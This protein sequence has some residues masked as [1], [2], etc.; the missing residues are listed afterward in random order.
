MLWFKVHNI[1]NPDRCHKVSFDSFCLSW[2][3][4]Y[5][6]NYLGQREPAGRQRSIV[7]SKE[8]LWLELQK[9]WENIS[10]QVL[11]KHPDTVP[12]GWP[13][14]SAA[15]GQN[16]YSSLKQTKAEGLSPSDSCYQSTYM[17]VLGTRR[18]KI[19]FG[20]QDNVNIFR[21]EMMDSNLRLEETGWCLNAE[22]FSGSG[23]SHVNSR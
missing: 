1:Q 4:D 10:V 19:M 16:K 18:N 13:S 20:K 15:K 3:S 11:S 14:A 17:H 6:R 8:N 23:Q 2:M 7:Q 22:Q 12:E 5:C 9:S 21:F